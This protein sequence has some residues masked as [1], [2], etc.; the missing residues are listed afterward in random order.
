MGKG[1]GRNQKDIRRGKFEAKEKSKEP[2]DKKKQRKEGS[3]K[4][5]RVKN[6]EAET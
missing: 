1:G 6:D 3:G 2:I 4:K 5:T